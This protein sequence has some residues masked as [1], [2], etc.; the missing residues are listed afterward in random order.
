MIKA[1]RASLAVLALMVIPM[2]Q[3]QTVTIPSYVEFAPG[4]DVTAAVRD[5][6]QLQTKL[7]DFIVQYGKGM[8]IVLSDN[9]E[10]AEGRYVMLEYTH[11]VGFGGG[12][13]SGAKSLLVSGEV[14]EG[15]KLIGSFTALRYSGGG[16][17]GNFKGT[18]AILGRCAKALGKDIARFLKN[19]VIGAKLGDRH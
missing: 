2:A 6:C 18:C 13:W 10:G 15:G 16:A 17:F 8:D 12:T 9:P 14:F 5:E 19:P 1:K 4:V 11:V 3:A 7:Q